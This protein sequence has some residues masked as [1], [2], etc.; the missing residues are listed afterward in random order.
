MRHFATRHPY[1]LSSWASA[2]PLRFD[3]CIED[4]ASE[5]SPGPPELNLGLHSSPDDLIDLQKPSQSMKNHLQTIKNHPKSIDKPLENHAPM[6][7][8][9]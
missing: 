6:Q 7:A 2:P 3:E 8:R 4:L 5:L 9:A 1:Y